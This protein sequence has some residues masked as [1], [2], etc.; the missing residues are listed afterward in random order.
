MLA[1]SEIRK[2]A[3]SDL[4][5]LRDVVEFKR[6]FYPVG[7]AHYDTA[8]PGSL[9]LIPPDVIKNSVIKDYQAM[10]DMIFGYRPSISEII[11]ILTDLQEQINCL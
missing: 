10:Q 5:L 11:T 7:W 4:P 6:K 9:Q 3:L 8:V 2:Q 1:S